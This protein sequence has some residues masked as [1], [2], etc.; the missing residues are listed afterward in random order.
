MEVACQ[1]NTISRSLHMIKI[2]ILTILLIMVGINAWARTYTT[3]FPLTEN[4]ISE[5]GNWINGATAGIDW[6]DVSTT[7]GQ[8][9]PHPGLARYADATALLMGAWGPD[10]SA[11]ATVYVN[12][13]Y[14]FPEVEFRLRSTLSPH[15]CNGYEITF[16]LAPNSYLLIVRWNGPLGNYTVLSNPSGT[17]YQAKPGDVVK[18]T[19][20]GHVITAYKNGVQMGQATDTTYITGNP[21]M[22]FNE[23]ANGDYG[24][25][26]FTVTDGIAA[27]DGEVVKA[28]VKAQ[29]SSKSCLTLLKAPHTGVYIRVESITGRGGKS[30]MRIFNLKGREVSQKVIQPY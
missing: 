18:A 7:P 16:S 12:N 15:V 29:P 3:S 20:V 27:T 2:H 26:N 28:Q 9:H 10:Q 5:N 21:G 30:S 23:Q 22:G 17:Q 24:Y 11:Q 4:P 13:A 25:T 8:T 14:N 6:G 1:L 19:I